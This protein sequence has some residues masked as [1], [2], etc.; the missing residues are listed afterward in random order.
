LYFERG[1]NKNC[2]YYRLFSIMLTHNPYNNNN[3]KQPFRSA[4]DGNKSTGAVVENA[5]ASIT[6][7][8]LAYRTLSSVDDK[9]NESSS[10]RE[11]A[12]ME[13]SLSGWLDRRI[14]DYQ[15]RL[16][17]GTTIATLTSKALQRAILQQQQDL[18]D[19]SVRQQQEL[20]LLQRLICSRS[21]ART[22]FPGDGDDDKRL[23]LRQEALQSRNR[24]VTLALEQSRK[25]DDVRHNLRTTAEKCRLLQRENRTQHERREQQQNKEGEPRTSRLSKENI[26][27]KRAMADLLA[28]SD[29]DWYPDIR[30]RQ[31][32]ARITDEGDKC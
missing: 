32:M 4:N 19:A 13:K 18:L 23:L 11:S 27:L 17:P 14:L 25:L 15:A 10:L 16:H 22:S 1:T 12:A 5:A 29:L 3:K 6:Q 7:T 9:N 30:L 24:Q 21:A 2:W 31:I 26:V 28:G 8:S 20:I